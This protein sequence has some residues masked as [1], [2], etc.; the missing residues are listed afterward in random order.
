MIAYIPVIIVFLLYFS[1]IPIAY[2]LF[3]RRI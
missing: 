3:P 1:G 2:A